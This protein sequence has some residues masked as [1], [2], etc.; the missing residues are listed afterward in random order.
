[1]R[2]PM[3][4][5]TIQTTRATV[6]FID[7]TNPTPYT[8]DIVLPRTYKNDD[9]ML[10]LVKQMCETP[11]IK[12]VAIMSSKVESALYGMSES[13]FVTHAHIIE[14]TSKDGIDNDAENN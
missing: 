1:M 11:T 8:N 12:A 6:M 2:K 4:T 7:S 13:D 3:I 14:K 5:R 9:A 10:K